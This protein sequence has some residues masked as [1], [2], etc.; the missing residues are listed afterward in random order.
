MGYA[1]QITW[2]ARLRI[3]CLLNKPRP[4]RIR[5]LYN[6]ILTRRP[7]SSPF[8]LAFL[9]GR[10]YGTS[11]P[12]FIIE[13]SIFVY[14]IND[15]PLCI[16]VIAIEIRLLNNSASKCRWPGCHTSIIKPG[17]GF[18]NK[19]ADERAERY[20]PRCNQRLLLQRRSTRI[21]LIALLIGWIRVTR[22]LRSLSY[23]IIN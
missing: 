2:L 18:G 19:G 13:T 11:L 21:N 14:L 20:H 1:V 9:S 4:G 3:S 7:I 17:G 15:E 5:I 12:I 6:S 16:L 8:R 22:V 23:N 10:K